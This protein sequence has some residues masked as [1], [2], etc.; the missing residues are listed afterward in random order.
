MHSFKDANSQDVT[1]LI[2]NPNFDSDISGWTT[3]GGDGNAYQRQTSS[4]ANF[5]GGFLE[6]W[7]N[8]WNGGYNQKNFDVYQTLS[9]LP[10]G[11]YTIKAAII[12][13]MQGSAETFSANNTAYSNK[14]HGGPY[15]IDD[16]KG[17][18]LYGTS[19]ENSGKAWA[20]TK[21]G[22]FDGD[23]AEYKTTTVKVENGSLTLG[24]KGVGST[25]GGTS[26]GTYANW[27]ACD[28]WTLSYFGFDPSTLKNHISDLQDDVQ[29]IIDGDEVPTAV[30]TS[31]QGTLDDL[32]VTP[33]TKTILEAAV[34]TLETAI[35][36]A[37]ATK[38]AY[39]K[40]KAHIT[41]VT[42]E[43]TNST[44]T[45]TDIEAA[46]SMATTNIET[47]TT[48]EDLTSDYNT[49]ESARQTY[50]T[51]GA[52]P[53]EDHVFDYT[54]KISNAAVTNTDGWTGGNT[55]SGQQ[56]TGAPDNTYF[57]RYNANINAYQEISDL[58]AGRYLVTAATRGISGL[59]TANIYVSQNGTNLASTNINKD[60][61]SGGTLDNGWSWTE[62][63]FEKT[64]TDAVRLGF[65]AECG[66]NK[67]AGADDFHLYYKGNF[68]TSAEATAILAEIVDGKMNAD[69]AS[70]Q[71]SAKD[72]FEAAN[73]V[74]TYNAL[75]TAINNA[76]AS[77]NAYTTGKAAI[78]K[79]NDI[80]SKTNVY[81]TEAYS[82]FSAAVTAAESKYADNS[83]TDSEATTF[84]TSTLGN[85][86]RS[87]A[88]VD[89][90]L[91]SA[92]DVAARNWDSYHVNSWSTTGDSGN[93]N[94]VVPA[95]EYWGDNA[96][97]LAD[98]V[99]T[100]TVA[101]EPYETYKVSAFISMAK[102]TTAYGEDA[103]TAPTGVTLQ[104]GEGD[105][106]NCTGTRV[107]ETRF[108]EGSFEA[109]GEADGSGNLTIKIAAAS[110]D[111]SWIM[112]RDVK[113]TK[114]AAAE[115]TAEE[116]AALLAA[117]NTVEAK[118][119]FEAGEYAPYNNVAGIAALNA[120]K[121][122]YANSTTKPAI[123]GTKDALEAI[124][125]DV[126]DEE[127]NAFYDGT[128]STR[129]VQET[130]TN[131]T[132]I[133]GWTSGD[134]IRQILK[135]EATFPGLADATDKTA[136]FAWSGGATYGNDEGYEIPL[137]ANTIY[138]LSL[139]V[140][141]WNNETRGNINVSVLK[142]SDGMASISLGKAD[143]DIK[144]NATNT[145][146]LT[147]MEILFVT[148]EAGNYIF[149]ISSPN[150]I[151]FT[152][153]ELKKATNQYLEFADDAAMAKYA[154]G[155]Y[156]SVKITRSLTA[157]RWAT[158]VYP[159][160]VSGVD[161]I[162]VLDSYDAE[163]GALGFTS[164][165]ASTAN[166]P[167]LMRSSSAKSEITLS[168]VAVAAAAVTDAVKSEAS[169]KG[170][171]TAKDITNAE[172][173]YVL[174]SNKIYSVGEA[175]ATINPYRAY[176]QIA[177]D[178]PAKALTFFVDDLPTA[179]ESIEAAP[180]ESAVIYNL[181]GQR[182]NKA[183]KGVNIINGHKVLVK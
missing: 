108:F 37:N 110:T 56:Y 100:A 115:A 41:F 43:K 166:V 180:Q 65:Y 124:V 168:D 82:T 90:F 83:W 96:S 86:W 129:E 88:S 140:A 138:K 5:T 50:V 42:S 183:Q 174:S 25:D 151:V 146:G 71:A 99:M 120:A 14:K 44:G 170:A 172:K 13:V 109:T 85:G 33:E 128:F 24:F 1:S 98:K 134:N 17:V 121:N 145:A 36:N 18:W 23:G 179:I 46:I 97:G 125:W 144:G 131:G 20:N 139:K 167:F 147:S 79:A 55:N 92:W 87:T 66:S 84:A 156:P 4:Q 47:R 101:V 122:A 137:K 163:T 127:L 8:G 16:E 70:A 157:N 72:A 165:D 35:E 162:A 11:E 68:V 59:G 181:A 117:I 169:L 75:R 76:T 63:P 15:Y 32:V 135:T 119:G 49:L 111:A 60:G 160:A 126:N 132:K 103:T 21:N 80:M 106:T 173:N 164:V 161:K 22:A 130:S 10:N 142:S 141:G 62:V 51:S 52:Q 77:K 159:F 48:A 177:Q 136:L 19:G 155:T 102:N 114:Q 58:P 45:K 182:L 27:I 133:P 153:V 93:P 107:E 143:K 31:L 152:D 6:K 78:D 7:R 29:A 158:A 39:A 3:T 53:T 118:I 105:A 150:N 91:I 113:Y 149:S 61:N 175:G 176:I 154:P 12:A 73:T 64:N 28:N 26:L 9:S 54:F 81:T 95:I 34:S 69:V 30:K 123:N 40:V 94:L 171:Y 116:K 89:D 67:W 2:T 148:G 178:A 74:A 112:F 38:E 104:V 57:D